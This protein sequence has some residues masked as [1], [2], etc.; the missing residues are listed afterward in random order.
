MGLV[1]NVHESWAYVCGVCELEVQTDPGEQPEGWRRLTIGRR[2]NPSQPGA[3]HE[4]EAW[5]AARFEDWVCSALCAMAAVIRSYRAP[6]PV[7]PAL[8][9]RPSVIRAFARREPEPSRLV[10]RSRMPVRAAA[11]DP[12]GVA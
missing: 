12:E 6:L 3:R 4:L 9:A 5:R 7:G 11:R 2:S 1:A 8:E 10:K